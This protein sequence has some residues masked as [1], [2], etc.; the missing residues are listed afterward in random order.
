LDAKD[1]KSNGSSINNSLSELMVVFGDAGKSE[2]SSFLNG[3]IKLLK[4]VNK[5]IKSS[6]VNNGLSEM[7]RMFCNRS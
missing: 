6:R 2:G 5:G 1:Q 4:A 3:W 7:W